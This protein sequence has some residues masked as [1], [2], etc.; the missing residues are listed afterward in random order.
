M[1]EKSLEM[2]NFNTISSRL[3]VL[4]MPFAARPSYDL[5]L[6]KLWAIYNF[7]IE[8]PEMEKACQK[9]QNGQV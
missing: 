3:S 1:D 9:Y 4:Y 8:M 2:V 7:S 6:I 5:L